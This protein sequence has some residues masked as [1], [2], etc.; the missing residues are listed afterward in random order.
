MAAF[1]YRRALRLLL[2]QGSLWLAL[3][4]S[5][6]LP[7]FLPDVF[8]PLDFALDDWRTRFDLQAGPESR[9]VIIDVDERSIARQGAWPWPR[10]TIAR[11]LQILIDDYG[12]ASIAIDMVFPE[13]RPNDDVLDV[14]FKRAQLT[15]AVVYDLEHRDLPMLRL[16]LP[17]PIPLRT[18]DQAPRIDGS[19][20]VANH[21]AIMP[22]R[23]GH[24]NP[25]FDTDGAVRRVYPIICNKGADCLP[26]LTV[27]SY[28]GM[29]AHPKLDLHRGQGLLSPAWELAINADDGTAIATIPVSR[30]GELVVPY[31]HNKKDW[32]SISASDILDHKPAPGLLKGVMVLMGGTALGLSDVIATPI[33]PVAAGLEPHAEILSALL[34]N[35]FAYVPQWGLVLDV[36]LL[37]PFCLLLAWLLGRFSKPSHRV[38]V[39][40]VWFALTWAC[41]AAVSIF[42]LRSANLLLPLSPLL[43]FPP[44][45]LAL[46]L[47][48][49]LYRTGAER[50]GIFSLLSAYLPR[51]VAARLVSVSQAGAPVDNAVDASRREITVMLADIHGFAG[52]TE[53]QSPEI[54]ARLM[55]R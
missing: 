23:V 28:A 7:T 11:L 31:R 55:Q 13:P 8:R 49:E 36:L 53:N 45:A 1:P 54:V 35:D 25:I 51:S 29:L 6:M 44:L 32:V 2:V 26:S 41:G 22:G 4:G 38:A 17:S 42:A 50:A 40:P 43:L 48:A 34:D 12:V 46:T 37:F 10:P 14:Q 47:L 9:I 33:S 18:A 19:P 39:F 15:G 5:V 52:L 21:A 24:I 3:A 27:N 30:G 20:V 16:A